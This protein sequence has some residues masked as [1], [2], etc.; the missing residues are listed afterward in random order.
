[1]RFQFV[2]KMWALYAPFRGAMAK[3][4]VF[5]LVGQLLSLATPFLF[6]HLVD[7]MTANALDGVWL[8]LCALVAIQF[9]QSVALSYFRQRFELIHIDW[10]IQ[11][12]LTVKTLE[13]FFGLSISQHTGSH[14]SLKRQTI[15]RGQD[16]IEEFGKLLIYELVPM[17]LE[18]MFMIGALFFMS[19]LLGSIVLVGVVAY[20][21]VAFWINKKGWRH[22]QHYNDRERDVNRFRDDA[23]SNVELVISFGHEKEMQRKI[24]HRQG[25]LFTLWRGFFLWVLKVSVARDCILSVTRAAVMACGVWFVIQHRFTPGEYV[26][27]IGLMQ[28]ALSRMG[29]VGQLQRNLIRYRDQ[30]SRYFEFMD[31]ETN[32]PV[33]KNPRPLGAVRG[34]IRFEGVTFKYESQERSALSG[35]SLLISAGETVAVVGE[36][37]AGKTTLIRAIGRAQDPE[38]GQVLVDGID[39]RLL[40]PSELR[41]AIGRVEQ[42]VGLFDDTVLANI[43]FGRSDKVSLEEVLV[44]CQQARIDRFLKLP[45][46]LYQLIGERGMKLSGGQRQRIGIARALLKKPQIL[47]FDEATSALD[48]ENE[49]S[50][51]E[52]IEFASKG[53]TTIIIAHRFSTI[54]S[55]KRVIVL[56]GGQVVGDG[57]HAELSR[58]C[59]EYQ[60]LIRRQVAGILQE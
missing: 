57:S 45:E 58:T 29:H 34:E 23:I 27:L 47:V 4:L 3:M 40:D 17:L 22:R 39:L 41:R 10:S 7:R 53:R 2:R 37:G 21:A 26:V 42:D 43:C 54:Q 19:W 46:G 8:V 5:L 50:I 60:R 33:M 38:R 12:Y 36:S 11:E 56:S 13:R 51:R 52:A 9:V 55:V 14:S 32:V 49:A 28:S 15:E 6:G 16:S 35:V 48:A 25:N 18:M 59:E 30:I 1:M 24:C 20:I 31:K 44:V